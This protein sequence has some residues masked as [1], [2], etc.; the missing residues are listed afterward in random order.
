MKLC[1]HIFALPAGNAN[2]LNLLTQNLLLNRCSCFNT[3]VICC[4]VDSW[5]AALRCYLGVHN[6]RMYLRRVCGCGILSS[7]AMMQSLGCRTSLFTDQRKGWPK[8]PLT[9]TD[10]IIS[11]QG[12]FLQYFVFLSCTIFS[13]INWSVK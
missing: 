12:R 1:S 8:I 7:K 13:V 6:C 10:M 4:F 3:A 11:F 2:L 9:Q 5:G